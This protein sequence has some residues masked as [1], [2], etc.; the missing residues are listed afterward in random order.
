MH[1]LQRNLIA[2]VTFLCCTAAIAA[3]AQKVHVVLKVPADT[4]ADAEVYLAGSLPAVG[5]W[6]AAGVKLERQK[7]GTYA[8][9]V[10]LEPDQTL[11]FKFTRGSWETVEKKADGT[12]RDN[13][14]VKI[15][16]D[17]KQID[18]TVEKWASN[19][20]SVTD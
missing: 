5:E 16:A 15:Q 14:S 4:P 6:K 20:S 8:A 11:E 9:D 3:A 7:D 18:A 1:S 10:E 19:G 12:D 17:T 2:I 13:R